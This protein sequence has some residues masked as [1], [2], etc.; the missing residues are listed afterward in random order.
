MIVHARSLG[1]DE[2]RIRIFAGTTDTIVIVGGET[3]DSR[4][5]GNVRSRGRRPRE[6]R[7]RII[8]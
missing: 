7:Y 3:A 2:A 8:T 4:A 5:R 6:R 1:G